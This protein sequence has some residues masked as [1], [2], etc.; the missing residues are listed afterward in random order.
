MDQG[1][2]SFR[3]TEG[4]V[5]V[6]NNTLQIS[7]T[8]KKFLRGQLSHRQKG[9]HSQQIAAIFR[10]FWFLLFPLY[11]IYQLYMAFGMSIGVV[12]SLSFITI[13]TNI[14]GFWMKHFRGTRIQLSDIEDI[15]LDVDNRELTIT[16]NAT[17]RLDV[18]GRNESKT[19][20]IL[21]TT[22]D[23]REA[24]AMFRMRGISVS[25]PEETETKYRVNTK[26]GVVF[27]EQCGSQVSP[28]N[29]TCS[30]CDYAL[31]IEQAVAD[32]SQELATEF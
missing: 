8:P 21:R 13:A 6:G 30:V 26:N 20:L 2:G 4:D 19:N 32:D 17:G 9:D 16:H 10:I 22:E 23:V 7:K 1:W 3:T 31:R 25:K 12:A 24:R 11:T 5:S 18:F 14:V 27:C 15:V 28:S 29:R